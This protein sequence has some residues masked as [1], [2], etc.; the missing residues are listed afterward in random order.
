MVRRPFTRVRAGAVVE[1]GGDGGT[2]VGGDG[3]EC[4]GHVNSF[5]TLESKKVLRKPEAIF[6]KLKPPSFYQHVYE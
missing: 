1:R 2:V 5:I 6:I 3:C 4:G